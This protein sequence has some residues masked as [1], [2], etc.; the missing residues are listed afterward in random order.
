MQFKGFGIFGP[1]VLLLPGLLIACGAPTRPSIEAVDVWARPAMTMKA[2]GEQ[3]GEGMG[4]GQ[5]MPGT[6]AVFMLLKNEGSE[7]DRLTGGQTDVAEVVEIHE[8]VMEGEVM[9]MQ[10]LPNGLEVPD[11]GEVLLK[12]GSYHI[13]LIGIKRDLVVG[14]AFALDLHFEKS[15][16]ITVEPKVREP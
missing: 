15:G 3:S 7:S 6:G 9:K 14:E 13:M 12:P 16:T 2:S 5:P 11:R 10:M 4:M 8:T 1:L